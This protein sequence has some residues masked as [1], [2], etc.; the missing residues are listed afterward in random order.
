[1]DNDKNKYADI[2]TEDG[3]VIKEVLLRSVKNP[4]TATFTVGKKKVEFTKSV[5]TGHL[6]SE[7]YSQSEAET[8]KNSISVTPENTVGIKKQRNPTNPSEVGYRVVVRKKTDIGDG[9]R[10]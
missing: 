2:E 8:V 10:V 6:Q 5:E 7:L 3:E 1:M 9:F 4:K